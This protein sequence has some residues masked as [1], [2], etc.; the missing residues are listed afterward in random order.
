V[1]RIQIRSLIGLAIILRRIPMVNRGRDNRPLTRTRAPQLGINSQTRSRPPPRNGA[2][3]ADG[4][5]VLVAS[6]IAISL[7]LVTNCGT[8]FFCDHD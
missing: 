2:D 8:A 3:G 7:T 1:V 4:P 5:V 6:A